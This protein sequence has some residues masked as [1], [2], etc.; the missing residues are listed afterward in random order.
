MLRLALR[1][2]AEADS[3]LP[4]TDDSAVAHL[5]FCFCCF[6]WGTSFILL[7]RVTH[8]MGPVEIAI[9]R[10]FSGAAVVGLCWWFKRG[11]Y[12]MSGSDLLLIAMASLIFTVPTQVIQAYVLEQGF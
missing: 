3:P 10:L 9:W 8:V 4:L 7:E 2:S 11:T 5:A 1:S 6:V 12:R